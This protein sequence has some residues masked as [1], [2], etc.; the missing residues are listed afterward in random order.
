[1]GGRLSFMAYEQDGSLIVR[2]NV[3][4]PCRSVG[5]SLAGDTLVCDSCGTTFKAKTGDGISG[6]C[7]AYPK[8]AAAY[9]INNGQ[10]VLKSADLLTAYQNTTAPGLP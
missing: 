10:A 3:C 1:G 2:A 5:F 9:D 8:A 7:V 4:P 6:A